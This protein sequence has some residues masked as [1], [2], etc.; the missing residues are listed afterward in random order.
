MSTLAKPDL[1]IAA[2]TVQSLA[3]NLNVSK[4][5]KLALFLKRPTI[6]V[7]DEAHHA[8]AP[9]ADVLLRPS[10]STRR[11]ERSSVLLRRLFPLQ[12]RRRSGSRNASRYSSTR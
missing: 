6:V 7:V 10:R 2:V 4:A 3:Y 8:G 5:E 11:F 12:S 9:N 1:D